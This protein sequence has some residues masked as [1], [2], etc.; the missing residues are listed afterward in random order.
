MAFGAT[1]TQLYL[2]KGKLIVLSG[3][4]MYGKTA[5]DMLLDPLRETQFESSSTKAS[6]SSW[7]G[8]PLGLG[9]RLL[10]SWRGP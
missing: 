6:S 8:V 10:C 3:S 9:E 5:I 1:Q 4:S 2:Y 7:V